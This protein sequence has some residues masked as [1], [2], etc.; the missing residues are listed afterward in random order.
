MDR[1]CAGELHV[2]IKDLLPNCTTWATSHKN[3]S[4]RVAG[5]WCQSGQISLCPGVDNFHY[6]GLKMVTPRCEM[7]MD[8]LFDKAVGPAMSMIGVF[9]AVSFAVAQAPIAY[10]AR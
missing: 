7:K 6:G 10:T 9:F 2:Q 4:I 8:H 5:A 3:A 1:S